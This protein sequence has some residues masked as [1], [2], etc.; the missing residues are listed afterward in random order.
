MDNSNNL[1]K[2]EPIVTFSK[3]NDP[4]EKLYLILIVGFDEEGNE[5]RDFEWVTGRTTAYEFIKDTAKEERAD[6]F[7]SKI[8]AETQPIEKAKTLVEFMRYCSDNELV[9]EDSGFDIMD[10]VQGDFEEG[11]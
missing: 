5:F 11:E 4:E 1:Q 10:Y 8:I 9:Q 2:P 6:L 3:P 7:Q